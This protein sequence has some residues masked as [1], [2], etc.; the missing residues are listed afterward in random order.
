MKEV[1]ITLA[2]YVVIMHAVIY[3]FIITI[4]IML[5]MNELNVIKIV[6]DN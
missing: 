2:L 1:I 3:I 6:K 4:I 5:T